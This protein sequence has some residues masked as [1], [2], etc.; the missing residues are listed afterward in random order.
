MS[1]YSLQDFYFIVDLD[2]V[3]MIDIASVHLPFFVYL[4][5]NGFS[6][7]F[8]TLSK[9]YH[10]ICR[11]NQEKSLKS[12]FCNLKSATLLKV[13]ERCGQNRQ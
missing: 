3:C 13:S 5:D 6:A 12:L 4:Q 7:I 9:L 1:R 10:T 11:M 8:F 2:P